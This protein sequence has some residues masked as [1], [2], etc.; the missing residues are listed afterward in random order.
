[1]AVQPN[2]KLFRVIR[3]HRFDVLQRHKL[4][5]VYSDEFLSKLIFQRCERLVDEIRLCAMMNCSVL[6]DGEQTPIIRQGYQAK[7]PSDTPREMTSRPG[8][9]FRRQTGQLGASSAGRSGERLAEPVAH[10]LEHVAE[11]SRAESLRRLSVEGR[12]ENRGRGRFE[13]RMVARKLA[14]VHARHAYIQR[15]SSGAILALLL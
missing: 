9:P 7:L 8:G 3:T 10:G 14:S 15:V 6:L 4:P 13:S 12:R 1:M 2:T 5:P 11:G